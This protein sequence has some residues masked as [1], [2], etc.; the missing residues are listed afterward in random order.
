MRPLVTRDNDWTIRQRLPGWLMTAEVLHGL[1]VTETPGTA[2]FGFVLPNGE[3]RDLT[4]A[5]I[6]V[7]AFGARYGF[8]SAPVV[9]G[10]PPLWLR[11][12]ATPLTIST[13]QHGRIVYVSYKRVTV[14]TGAAAQ[15]ILRLAKAK[16]FRRVIVDVRLNGGGD[17]HTYIP[18]L[19]ALRGRAVNRYARP[20]VLMGRA[21]FSA[22]Q[23]FISELEQRPRPVFV[24]EPSGGSPNL[25]GDNRPI[26]LPGLG[27]TAFV[28]QIYWVKSRPD[29]PRVQ[30]EPDVLVDLGSA[31]FF[32]GRDPVLAA[33]LA[34]P[35]R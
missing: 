31:D 27:L 12:A 25:Y 8:N 17:N 30:I 9:R 22:A 19:A 35:L 7:D 18:L 23:N 21:T 29:D 16:R 34:L 14:Q 28:P 24:G 10:R 11:Q 32:A 4:L 6:D 26:D 3:R 1:R 13:L 2:A 20:V 33:A 5:P 15:R